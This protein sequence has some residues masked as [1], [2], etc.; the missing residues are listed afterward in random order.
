M[1]HVTWEP[2]KNTPS[3]IA[4]NP[5]H[6]SNGYFR[7][8][9]KCRLIFF[10]HLRRVWF[11][12]QSHRFYFG[13]WWLIFFGLKCLLDHS[14]QLFNFYYFLRFVMTNMPPN[15]FCLRCA[16][17][18]KMP[19]SS[20]VSSN[21]AVSLIVWGSPQCFKLYFFT[22]PTL[23]YEICAMLRWQFQ[24]NT[25][26]PTENVQNYCVD[27]FCGFKGYDLVYLERKVH[28]LSLMQY[29][30]KYKYETVNNLKSGKRT[31]RYFIS[32]KKIY[33]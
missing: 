25:L 23:L 26:W 8:V 7:V 21:G 1:E 24:Q 2:R 15:K 14:K 17:Y 11:W 4:F 12:R 27:N 13:L 6:S 29:Y 31:P 20:P 5:S 22:I 16:V 10:R 30:I 3:S 18:R 19:M 33:S 32:I 9:K 28:L